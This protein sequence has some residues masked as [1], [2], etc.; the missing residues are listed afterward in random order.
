MPT[1]KVN[2]CNDLDRAALQDSRGNTI[3]MMVQSIVLMVLARRLPN[4][5]ICSNCQHTL[6]FRFEKVRFVRGALETDV[7]IGANKDQPAV[8]WSVALREGL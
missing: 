1:A 2:Q 8:A 6:K 4:E 3:N 7:S 5:P